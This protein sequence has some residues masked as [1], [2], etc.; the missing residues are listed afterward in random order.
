MGKGS[1]PRPI[2]NRAKFEE[3]WD[4][5]FGKNIP[6]ADAIEHIMTSPNYRKKTPKHAATQTHTDK[7]K[8]IPRRYKYNN[9]EEQL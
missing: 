7:T 9:I 8:V 2:P 5:I 6:S 3:N 4:R 1:K